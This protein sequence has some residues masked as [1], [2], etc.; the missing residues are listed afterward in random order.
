MGGR[1]HDFFDRFMTKSYK[2][3][4]RST[5]YPFKNLILLQTDTIAIFAVPAG[6]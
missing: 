3:R 1:M 6:P 2:N 5:F 4:E